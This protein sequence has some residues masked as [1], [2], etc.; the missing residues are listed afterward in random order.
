MFTSIF[1]RLTAPLLGLFRAGGLFLRG[2]C[3]DCDGAVCAGESS[4]DEETIYT[5][6]D[7]SSPVLS[8]DDQ[9]RD[10]A[11]DL[12]APTS[13]GSGIGNGA[14]QTTHSAYPGCDHCG[15]TWHSACDSL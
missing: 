5:S 10:E 2:C 1:A 15:V 7:R 12:S 14:T 9:L 13:L 11:Y 6:A 8:S 4:G 3:S